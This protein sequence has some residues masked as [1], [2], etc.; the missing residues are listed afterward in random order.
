MVTNSARKWHAFISEHETRPDSQS[1]SQSPSHYHSI[2]KG[3]A[4]FCENHFRQMSEAPARSFFILCTYANICSGPTKIFI[5]H[6]FEIWTFF[7]RRAL[8]RLRLRKQLEG[9]RES[10]EGVVTRAH[11]CGS[12]SEKGQPQWSSKTQT[13]SSVQRRGSKPD[14]AGREPL[15][16]D[17]MLSMQ[18]TEQRTRPPASRWASEGQKASKGANDPMWKHDPTQRMEE[19]KLTGSTTCVC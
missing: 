1:Q 13:Q 9:T 5:E 6:D 8:V 11:G 10:G 14:Y 16:E 4:R 17:S 2:R 15:F 7:I 12:G 19:I 3:I 18:S